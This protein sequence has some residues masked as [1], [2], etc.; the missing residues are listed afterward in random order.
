MMQEGRPTADTT[1]AGAHPAQAIYPTPPKEEDEKSFVLHRLKEQVILY[2]PQKGGRPDG[3][4]IGEKTA[5]LKF[6]FTLAGTALIELDEA[7]TASA[8]NA[9]MDACRERKM[10]ILDRGT[11]GHSGIHLGVAL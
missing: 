2:T 8:V 1:S 7:F 9:E 11:R 5:F 3:S 10:P 4:V 6:Y